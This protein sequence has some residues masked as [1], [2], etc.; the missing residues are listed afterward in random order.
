M[1]YTPED[2]PGFDEG[3]TASVA[4]VMEL[5]TWTDELLKIF[6]LFVAGTSKLLAKNCSLGLILAS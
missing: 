3:F 1:G 5:T 6:Q 2:V 4:R